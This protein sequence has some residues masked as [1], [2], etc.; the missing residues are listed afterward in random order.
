MLAGLVSTQ[1]QSLPV[2]L[3][4]PVCV[5]SVSQHTQKQST[6]ADSRTSFFI[7]VQCSVSAGQTCSN[8]VSKLSSTVKVTTSPSAS[9]HIS[10]LFFFLCLSWMIC[11]IVTSKICF[12]A[13]LVS[14]THPN[15]L[16][17]QVYIL[18]S[19]LSPSW[20][21]KYIFSRQDFKFSKS[22]RDDTFTPK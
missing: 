7:T 3:S 12:T 19:L 5:L 18:F 2:R 15:R 22:L 20:S 21:S 17:F 6:F 4:E 9:S 10:R 8:F 1:L 13:S 16:D 14:R 11:N